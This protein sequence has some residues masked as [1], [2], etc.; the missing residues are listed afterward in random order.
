[1]YISNVYQ[2]SLRFHCQRFSNNAK[3][4]FTDQELLTVYFFCG[5]YQRYFNIKEI[6][7]FTKEYLRHGSQ[8]CPLIIH[9]TIG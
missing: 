8:T 9:S 5:A 3:P 7:T 1:M 2:S 4:I 6:H